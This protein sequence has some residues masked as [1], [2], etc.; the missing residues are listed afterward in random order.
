MSLALTLSMARYRTLRALPL[1]LGR[2]FC[3]LQVRAIILFSGRAGLVIPASVATEQT[4]RTG[5]AQ[6]EWLESLRASRW[7]R[8]VGAF[9]SSG[10]FY[11]PVER[12]TTRLSQVQ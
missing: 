11:W 6:R 2:S 8:R 9:D 12:R 10:A 5:C 3:G 1:R 7:P 4:C